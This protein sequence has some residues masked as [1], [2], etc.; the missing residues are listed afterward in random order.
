[1]IDAGTVTLRSS[2]P[3]G[4]VFLG[5]STGPMNF[6]VNVGTTLA[7][8]NSLA[9]NNN[10]LASNAVVTVAGGELKLVG[11][12]SMAVTQTLANPS[13]TGNSTITVTQPTSG[14]GS[15]TTLRVAP[16]AAAITMRATTLN[17]SA[18]AKLDLT[19]NKLIAA[20]QSVG[21]W[22]GS[23][24]TGITGLIQSGRGDGSWNG[25][26][27]TTS[28]TDA[29]TGVLTTLAVG[30]A[31]E[32]GYAGGTFGGVSVVAGDTIVFYTWGGDADLNGE[33]NGDDY[34][35]I[36]S[37]ILANQ[38][39]A[40]NAS[41][42]NGDV[43][44]DGVIDGDDYFVLDSNILYAQG[45]GYVFPHGAGSTGSPQAGA[46]L[47]AVP[48]PGSLGVIAVLAALH[49]GRRRG[50]ALRSAPPG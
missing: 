19:D 35:Y 47:T 23:A 17:L 50:A 10:R 24:Y 32:L 2:N 16:S 13:V 7:L 34:F 5:S 29:T 46:G 31:D 21:T 40:N 20:G 28:M 15:T 6:R 3:S 48:E 27:I 45:S 8:D 36:D 4:G 38:A 33:L 42:H 9:A 43:N 44:Y 11:N 1:V 22:N 14:N 18:G 25:E 26:G 37:N 49:V 12:A 41:F 30:E 39:G